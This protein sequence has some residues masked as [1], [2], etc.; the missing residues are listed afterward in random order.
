[1]NMKAKIKKILT[2]ERPLIDV[3]YY[4][5]GNVRYHLYYGGELSRK[6]ALIAWLRK[7]LIRQHIKEQIDFRIKVMRPKCY[8]EGSCEICGCETTKLQMAD[9]ACEGHC[10]PHMFPRY[11]WK[12]VKTIIYDYYKPKNLS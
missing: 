4:I 2:G 1:M 6:Y 8:N 9:K 7:H 5:Q 11:K 10:Y 12:E 3:W